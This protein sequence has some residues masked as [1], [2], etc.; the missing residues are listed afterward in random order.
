MDKTWRNRII[1]Y[2]EIAANQL[3]ANPD[4]PRIHPAKQLD[5][6]EGS[7]SE[8]GWYDVILVNKRTGYLIDGHARVEQALSLNETMKVPVL[9]VDLTPEE[10]ALAIATHDYMTYLAT[11]EPELLEG[12]LA[13][14]HAQS[15]SL[16]NLIS[17]LASDSGLLYDTEPILEAKD[18]RIL[19]DNAAAW[20]KKWG[21]EKG[22]VW[23]AG[24]HKIV[25][26]DATDETLLSRLLKHQK[27][28]LLHTDPPYGIEI[29]KLGKGKKGN[30]TGSV[31]D[32]KPFGSMVN[33]K[34]SG[35]KAYVIETNQYAA[36]EG[37]DRPFDPAYL[38]GLA[39]KI[40]LWGANYFAHVLPIS[41]GWIIWD[42]REGIVR[43][44][45][46]DCEMAWTNQQKPARIFYHL[47]NGLH[48]GSQ[49]GQKRLHP[50]EKPI[51]LFAEIGN[52]LAPGGLW[53]DLYAG[54]GAQLVAAEQTAA[55]CYA[56]D[57][58][59]LYVA[60]TL[61]RLSLMGL[62]PEKVTL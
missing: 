56:I 54:S 61:E 38:L 20:L 49:H 60:T 17:S 2:A 31:G 15:L 47:W 5:A 46:A 37:D 13:K 23:K 26:W 6:L 30:G 25:C 57:I 58:E 22:Q 8:L 44:D 19:L 7:L 34:T 62:S 32:S 9:Y 29:V 11:Y 53:L 33:R 42:K 3:L 40:V 28:D 14:T 52:L 36:I 4:N 16:Q 55:T 51:A 41:S 12:L 45:F 18:S 24:R 27:P 1:G 59:P 35:S 10:E 43:N 50:T 48:K 21:V 39:P